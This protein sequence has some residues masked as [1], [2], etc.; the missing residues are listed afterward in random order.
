M[1]RTLK[2]IILEFL[3]IVEYSDDKE[4]FIAEFEQLN[5]VE[6]F[7]NVFETLPKDVQEKIKKSKPEEI[8]QYI[9][10]DAFEKELIKVSSIAFG[11]QIKDTLPILT[12]AQKEKVVQ[13][14]ASLQNE[15]QQ[16]PNNPSE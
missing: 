7:T 4:K 10:K 2:D 16:D 13:L 9:P 12:P 1:K 14:V 8:A 3:A 5:Q 15:Q 6:A 11:E